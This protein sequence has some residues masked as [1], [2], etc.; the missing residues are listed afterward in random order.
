MTPRLERLSLGRKLALTVLG[1]AAIAGPV[2]FG[3]LR[4]IPIYGQLLHATGPLPSFEVASIKPG[5]SGAQSKNPFAFS[6]RPGGNYLVRGV[7]IRSL[8]SYAYGIG[9]APELSGGPKWIGTDTFDIEAKP[10]E[11]EAATLN[12]LSRNDKEEQM[13]LMVQSLLT[14]RFNLK[15]SFEKRDVPMY[16]LVVAKGGLKCTKSIDQA[17]PAPGQRFPVM[18]PPPP[19]PPAPASG[20]VSGENR[21][22]PKR[23]PLSLIVAHLS[24][25]QEVGGRMVVDKTGLEGDYDCYLSWAREG[26]DFPGPSFFTAIQ[27]QMGLKLKATKGPVEVLV[28]DHID[29]PSAN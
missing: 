9:F 2:A 26:S 11:V 22:T 4:M 23:W 13:R 28:V 27:E 14:E 21:F 29:H 6:E 8:I 1:F 16:T 17:L 19:P 18:S 25:Q 10:D 7:T 15:V 24:T 20:I 3:A 5:R 12:K